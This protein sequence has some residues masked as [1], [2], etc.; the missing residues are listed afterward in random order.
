MVN[1]KI[2][3]SLKQLLL[4]LYISSDIFVS[5]KKKSKEGE[6]SAQC[7]TKILTDTLLH[8]KGCHHCHCHVKTP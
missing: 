2:Q 3:T 4:F 8:I 7:V 5:D 1:S 6:D